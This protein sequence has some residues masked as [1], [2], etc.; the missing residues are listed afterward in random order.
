MKTLTSLIDSRACLHGKF[1]EQDPAMIFGYF[2]A[3]GMFP[4][5]QEFSEAKDM[6]ACAKDVVKVAGYKDP[7]WKDIVSVFGS[8]Y[9]LGNAF[10]GKLWLDQ[11]KM[12]RV[13][14][15][16]YG[17]R[18]TSSSLAEDWRYLIL[19]VA[20]GV[21]VKQPAIL[22]VVYP[23]KMV[24]AFVDVNTWETLQH[25]AA[26]VYDNREATPGLHCSRCSDNDKCPRFLSWV[27]QNDL[28]KEEV[29]DRKLKANRLYLVGLGLRAKIKQAEAQWKV[30]SSHLRACIEEG[31]I[32]INDYF[33]L[34]A[35]SAERT[36]YPF[37]QTYKILNDAKLWKPPFG[38]ILGGE[39]AKSWDTF[40][41]GIKTK[42]ESIRQVDATAPS[43]REVLTNGQTSIKAM[44]IVVGISGRK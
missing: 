27:D 13:T 29:K 43:L 12:Q 3:C 17:L 28:P 44:P 5:D 30:V 25:L 22:E 26:R 11:D 9:E 24:R 7:V 10:L 31:R 39:V 37:D 34:D 8:N 18:V 15:P 6:V 38:K 4:G 19:A 14:F 2:L 33:Y 35:P 16:G 23:D 41:V 36:S 20:S 1:K 32:N 40:P 42:L 21:D